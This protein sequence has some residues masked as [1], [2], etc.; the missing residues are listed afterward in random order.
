MNTANGRDALRLDKCRS[1]VP[2][3]SLGEEGR[4][5]QVFLCV[6]LGPPASESPGTLNNV[7]L[8]A[9]SEAQESIY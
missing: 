6:G 9:G 5:L 4:S 3:G 2:G 7:D 1:S 8:Q